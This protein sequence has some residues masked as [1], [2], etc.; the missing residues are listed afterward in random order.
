MYSEREVKCPICGDI[1]LTR[2][3]TWVTHCGRR[4]KISKNLANGNPKPSRIKRVGK[5]LAK[6]AIYPD[7]SNVVS[8]IAQKVGGK[9]VKQYAKAVEKR[10]ESIR[11]DVLGGKVTPTEIA[12][13][14][15][16][17]PTSNLEKPTFVW[18]DE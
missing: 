11:S 17:K 2:K 10:K 14:Q 18:R 12:A 15:L 7:P 5:A 3:K 4:Y 13:S 9:K 1:F 6:Q 8:P 16:E